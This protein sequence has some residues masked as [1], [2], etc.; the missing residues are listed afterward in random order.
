M[1][2]K[3]T[4]LLLVRNR[5]HLTLPSRAGERQLVAEDAR[6]IAFEGSPAHARWLSEDEAL[7]VTAAQ[8]TENTAPEFAEGAVSR[9]LD[10]LPALD[11]YLAAYGDERAAELRESHRRVRGASEQRLRGLKVEAQKPA[12]ILGVYV[13]LPVVGDSTSTGRAV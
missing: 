1:V 6:L 13:Y 9:V 4:T 12:D 5:F 2:T 8:A 11:D 3:R 7:A 10:D